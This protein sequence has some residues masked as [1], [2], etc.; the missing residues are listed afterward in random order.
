MRDVRARRA[1][2]QDVRKMRSEARQK[3]PAAE[4]EGRGKEQPGQGAA[5]H[6]RQVQGLHGAVRRGILPRGRVAAEQ[7]EVSE[8]RRLRLEDL[9]RG[10][11]AERGN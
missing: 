7:E 11:T 6:L 2:V 10:N 9:R 1:G 5:D 8:S 4:G 3:Q